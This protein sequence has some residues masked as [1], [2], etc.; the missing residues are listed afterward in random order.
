MTEV[1]KALDTHDHITLHQVETGYFKTYDEFL[2]RYYKPIA[3]GQVRCHHI[4]TA[5]NQRKAFMTFKTDMKSLA[6][7]FFTMSFLKTGVELTD[8]ERKKA[9][10][11]WVGLATIPDPGVSAK[12]QVHMRDHWRKIVPQIHWAETCPSPSKAVRTKNKLE[13][14][15]KK[16]LKQQAKAKGLTPAK[17]TAPAKKAAAAKRKTAPA[18]TAPAKKAAGKKTAAAKKA[19]AKKAAAKKAPAKRKTPPTGDAAPSEQA[20]ATKKRKA[21]IIAADL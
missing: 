15:K 18:K 6:K 13:E 9:L 7:R 3:N 8:P 12:K 16:E 1:V 10:N 11:D 5:F 4:F 19:P 2:D 14:H 20:R 21:P 17:K